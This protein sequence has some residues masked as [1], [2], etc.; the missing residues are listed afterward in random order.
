M[1]NHRGLGV[2]ANAPVRGIYAIN[3][4][5]ATIDHRVH[6]VDELVEAA[7]HSTT[8]NG[9]KC[10]LHLYMQSNNPQ[11][12]ETICV[13]A[14]ER[15]VVLPPDFDAFQLKWGTAPG[16]KGSKMHEKHRRR[17]GNPRYNLDAR[18]NLTAFN[19]SVE[20]G[21]LLNLPPSV[22]EPR[23]EMT[24]FSSASEDK[25][26]DKDTMMDTT[27]DTT[28]N[29]MMDKTAEDD[30]V[31]VV[32]DDDDNDEAGKKKKKNRRVTRKRK[33]QLMQHREL[34]SAMES[35]SAKTTTTASA[36]SLPASGTWEYTR[37]SPPNQSISYRESPP[38]PKICLPNPVASTVRLQDSFVDKEDIFQGV[39]LNI[40]QNPS[41]PETTSLE[42]FD[43]LTLH[44]HFKRCQ[45]KYKRRTSVGDDMMSTWRMVGHNETTLRNLCRE[46]MPTN[47]N[48]LKL[49][50]MR[51]LDGI[52]TLP[53]TH[54]IT[55][56]IA[57]TAEYFL[58][59]EDQ[60]PETNK[61]AEDSSRAQARNE[62]LARANIAAQEEF[63]DKLN[64]PSYAQCVESLRPFEHFIVCD[65]RETMRQE[66]PREIAQAAQEIVR[67]LAEGSV[68][69]ENV[70]KVFMELGFKSLEDMIHGKLAL[71]RFR[72]GLG[73][74]AVVEMMRL[75]LRT[76]PE[77]YMMKKMHRV[78][79]PPPPRGPP[80]LAL[81]MS[82]PPPM[83]STGFMTAGPPRNFAPFPSD[84]P[85]WPPPP[86]NFM[87]RL[88]DSGPPLPPPP[89]FLP[90]HPRGQE[91]T[92]TSVPMTELKK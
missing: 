23:S 53:K 14:R 2:D 32:P 12:I 46:K 10:P 20:E 63:L 19:Q 56:V 15:K 71:E 48:E 21:L 17:I 39:E 86:R 81:Q 55:D 82:R 85:W 54:S 4:P 3:A 29:T 58:P 91:R 24:S 26:K 92:L 37:K 51:E 30:D 9:E 44:T 60:S 16:T 13:W 40:P 89:N 50:L 35:S 70:R 25:D 65:L 57:E 67:K 84:G 1:Q 66:H 87:P 68:T 73:A 76:G 88:V 6:Y 69:L 80:P 64:K 34:L 27:M 75:F 78:R 61:D 45:Q 8:L 22:G 90:R 38:L 52:A 5:N 59:S 62:E 47:Q 31:V 79:P 83:P 33:M 36:V 49:L 18:H 42:S 74:G 77:Q 28:M 41:L 7:I 43:N 11:D 72:F